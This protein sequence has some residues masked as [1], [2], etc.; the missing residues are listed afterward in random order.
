[1]TTY[2]GF[3]LLTARMDAS[4]D[5]VDTFTR[6]V[7]TFDPGPMKRS[8]QTR[9]YAPKVE[10]PYLW[11]CYSL[12]QIAALKDFI[13]AR[14]GRINPL[15]IPS[16]R[17]DLILSLSALSSDTQVTIQG[18]GYSTFTFPHK[19]RRNV[20]FQIGTNIIY[21]QIINAQDY[22]DYE[23]LTL[24]SSLGIAAPAGTI[25]S[26]LL[27]CRLNSDS[28]QLTYPAVERAQCQLEF[29]EL[30]EETP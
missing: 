1:M 25:L 22:G 21:R 19:A 11:S 9:D 20:Q 15:W 29:I 27:F 17:K 7:F 18:V 12:A 3:E 5:V 10:H 8:V 30:P 28:I 16:W 26:Y 2:R 24:N 6:K 14:V 23:V 4:E 13:Q